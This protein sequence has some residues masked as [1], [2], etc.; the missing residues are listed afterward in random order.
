M[1]YNVITGKGVLSQG[2]DT[3]LEV[4]T[5]QVLRQD[6]E[7]LIHCS[8]T[9]CFPVCARTICGRTNHSLAVVVKRH[10]L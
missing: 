8:H 2:V 9:H 7:L 5:Q 4:F 10:V 1:C 3:G 6:G